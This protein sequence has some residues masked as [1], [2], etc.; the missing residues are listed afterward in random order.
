VVEQLTR[1]RTKPVL[2]SFDWADV[3]DFHTLMA[4]AGIGG[5]AVPL[6]WASATGSKPKRGRNAPE[7]RLLRALK[8]LLPPSCPVTIPADRGFG[9]AERAAV[10]R[11]PGFH[12]VVRIKPDVVVAGPRYRGVLRS[13]PVREGMAHVLRGADYRRDRRVE[14][15]V[16]ARRKPGLPTERDEPWYLMTDPEGRA[17][18]LCG[19][20]GRRMSVE[21][22]SRDG[23][24]RRTGRSSRGTRIT[25]PDR[26]DRFLIVVALAYLLL[27]GL[28]PKARPDSDPSAWC[29]SRRAGECRVLTIGKAR[30][31]R[32]DCPP[33]QVLRMLRWATIEVGSKWG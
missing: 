25:Y 31:D 18:K 15:H 27:V 24:G 9:R 17:E 12:Y 30:I 8:G 20:Y 7:E 21:E 6:L 10:C 32:L 5:R 13:Y 22:L 14:H 23:Q 16:V 1:D 19:L 29:T 11:E 26:F 33:E 2:V 28:G 3:R 4:A